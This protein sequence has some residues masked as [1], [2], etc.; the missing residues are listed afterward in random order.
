MITALG[1]IVAL[2]GLVGVA[3]LI[4]AWV[5]LSYFVSKD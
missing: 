4:A 2:V 1:M 3:A 5:L